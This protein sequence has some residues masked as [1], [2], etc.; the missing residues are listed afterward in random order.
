MVDYWLMKVRASKQL[1]TRTDTGLLVLVHY[2]FVDSSWN[3]PRPLLLVT[4]S[5]PFLG[6][7]RPVW[8]LFCFHPRKYIIN[9][10][11]CNRFYFRL[12]VR[13]YFVCSLSADL[14]TG[15]A[16]WRSLEQTKNW[17]IH[18]II[19]S[20]LFATKEIPFDRLFILSSKASAPKLQES[21]KPVLAP[22]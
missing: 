2:K 16:L 21:V 12:A 11:L 19:S 22:T 6:C 3:W 18:L 17:L 9:N 15:A 1:R 10:L 14:L 8:L 13:F 4:G 5:T 20:D 7:I